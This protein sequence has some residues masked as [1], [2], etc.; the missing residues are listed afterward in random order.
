MTHV[1]AA[2][3]LTVK[4][5][6]TIVPVVPDTSVTKVT[7]PAVSSVAVGGSAGGG[8]AAVTGSVVVDV[9]SLTTQAWIGDGAQINQTTPSG[10]APQTIT[11]SAEDNT[12]LTNVAGALALTEGSAGIAFC[13]F[14]VEID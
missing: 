9:I 8:D 10:G 14:I 3:A 6:M 4:A 2:K 13:P 11:V 1:D 12:K 7:L 5:T